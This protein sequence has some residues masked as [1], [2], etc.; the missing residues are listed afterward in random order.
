MGLGRWLG[1]RRCVCILA[2][3]WVQVFGLE[4]VVVVVLLLLFSQ[5]DLCSSCGCSPGRGGRTGGGSFRSLVVAVGAGLERG[6]S[7]PTRG[8]AGI[9]GPSLFSHLLRPS[10]TASQEFL[11]FKARTQLH[12][13]SPASGMKCHSPQNPEPSVSP[14][15]SPLRPFQSSPPDSQTDLECPAH[16]DSGVVSRRWIC[17]LCLG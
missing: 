17:L 9:S 7:R 8:L 2:G 10:L 11:F 12:L 16:W 3:G 6:I 5:G 4:E 1:E 15:P 13:A 14:S